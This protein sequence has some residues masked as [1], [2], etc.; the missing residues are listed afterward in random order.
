MLWLY[1]WFLENSPI[2]TSVFLTDSLCNLYLVSCLTD[3]LIQI[4][5]FRLGVNC[6]GVKIYI[7][8]KAN[9]HH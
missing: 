4:L 8:N 1:F 9:L 7:T 5:N 6:L 2:A 3:I